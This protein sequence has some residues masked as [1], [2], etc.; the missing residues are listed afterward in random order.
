MSQQ[1]AF[2]HAGIVLL[3]GPS[4]SGK[5]SLLNYLVE[6]SILL[7]SEIVSSDQFR[8]LVSD[9]DFIDYG[10]P[11]KDEQEVLFA[12]YQQISEKAFESMFALINIRCALGKLTV[13]DA[14]HLWPEDRKKS[15]DIANKNH[16]PVM[17]IVLDVPEKK[18]L[19]RDAQREL[20]RGRDRI[21]K[22][23][24]T[25]KNNLRSLK[26]E[27]F[28]VLYSLNDVEL[29]QCTFVRLFNPIVKEVGAGLDFIGDIHGCYSE[30]LELLD[31]LGY[32]QNEEG[33]YVH[34]E[35]R[36]LVSV[37]DILGR[38][39][40]SIE[41]LKFF[42]NHVEKELAYMVDSNHGWKIARWLSGR[43]VELAHGDEIVAAEFENLEK[44]QGKEAAEQFKEKVKNFLL[45]A[46]SNLVF[47]KH[48]VGVIV[49][50]HAG[51]RD[52]YIGKQSKRISD[53][54]RYGDTDGA[55]DAGKPIRKDWFVHHQSG[56]I[57]V[58][59]HDPRPLPQV[60]NNTIN[61]DQGVVFGGRLTAY[62]YPQKTF[63]SVVAHEDYANDP[64]SF[65]QKWKKERFSPPNIQSFLNGFSVST[66]VYGD[67]RIQEE[68]VKSSIEEVSHYTVPIEEL[69]YIPPTM[70]PTTDP[71]PQLDYLEHPKEA[72]EYYRK[73]GITTMVVEKK[74]M[75]SRAILLLFKDADTAVNYVGNP[76]LGTI[77]TRTGRAFF[78]RAM[79]QTVL[80]QLNNDLN[81]AQYFT[82]NKTDF[83][84]LDAE[85][86]PWNLKA[87]ELISA[88][89]AHVSEV[90]IMDRQR[91]LD[92]LQEA[93]RNGWEVN[94]WLEEF[95]SKLESAEVFR[96]VFQKYCWDTQGIEGIK[97]AAFHVL[98][99]SKRTNFDQPHLWHMEQGRELVQ[100]S[101]LFIETEYKVVK[102]EASEK[103]A[104]RWWQEITED[105]HEGFVVKPE[106]YIARNNKGRLIQPAIKV[107]GRNYLHIIYGI[108]YLQSKNLA[109]LKQRNVSRKQRHALMEFA[110]GIEGVKRFVDKEP[111]ER[112]HECVLATLAL[113]AEPVDPRL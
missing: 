56:E 92:K 16:V 66:E 37:G 97:I 1:I 72:F 48:R 94:P 60:I 89:Y 107:R 105:G 75:G 10:K 29:E 18:L 99:Y 33:L 15:I 112:V 81:R 35:G 67:I 5:S 78:D 101:D 96:A 22:Q 6:Q 57:I 11:S 23:V 87:K 36:K 27:G 55:D 91:M 53:F 86:L 51:I 110:L 17:A 74:H 44:G 32:L 82:K 19:E 95:K 68:F 58:W 14:T 3:V 41:C 71:S 109:R 93:E 88:Q 83:V 108:D 25:F 24:R 21:K 63:V 104:I 46:P 59:G 9:T 12:K 26:T 90:A 49:A 43:N 100:I 34:P 13:V 77:Y 103:E 2:P 50:T 84:L 76:T 54:C 45:T 106:T 111:V 7:G 102:D 40:Q 98:A 113:E 79:T 69:V 64:E 47:L 38:G 31:K 61:I 30:Y 80:G 73:Q 4:N 70:S 39:P 65:L 62:R 28:A 20:P 52:S 85:I 8:V 42:I